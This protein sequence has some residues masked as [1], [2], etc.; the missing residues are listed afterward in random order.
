[1][2]STKYPR[3]FHLPF[4]PGVSN[5]DKIIS[6]VKDLIGVELV[7]TEKIDG[8][9]VC[10]QCESLH[11]RSHDGPPRH[12]S[13]DEL[14]AM[15]SGIRFL[16]PE[17]L[18]VFGE[19]CAAIKSLEYTAVLP[20]Y[21]FVFGIRQG[22][23]TW[24]AW[25]DVVEYANTNGFCAV[26]VIHRGVFNDIQS[27]EKRINQIM[28]EPSAYGPEK[29]GVVVRVATAFDDKKFKTHVAKYVRA[30]HVQEDEHWSKGMYSKH[31]VQR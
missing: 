3:T 5:T 30:N 18:Q 8:S 12:P 6:S 21:L 15:H 11:A 4:S 31:K 19:W 13:Y 17:D 7:I 2:D 1:M 28:M 10:L 29:E 9:N 20:S 22:Y 16:I 14:K 26:P 25:D 23:K 24:L 27:L